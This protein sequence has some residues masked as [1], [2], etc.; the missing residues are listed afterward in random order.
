MLV[1]AYTWHATATPVIHCGATPVF[2]DIRAE[3]MTIPPV[4]GVKTRVSY[5]PIVGSGANTCTLHYVDNDQPLADGDLLLQR[6]A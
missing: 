3:S 5:S 1:P 6:K 2:C 4:A